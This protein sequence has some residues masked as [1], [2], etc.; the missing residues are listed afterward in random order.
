[1][2]KLAIF[3]FIAVFIGLN[4]SFVSAQAGRGTPAE[5]GKA[6]KRPPQTSPTPKPTPTPEEENT[7]NIE[8]LPVPVTETP[9]DG[10]I[11]K[12]D[13]SVVT[14]PVKV[15]DR[16][17]RFIS[18]LTKEDFKVWEDNVEQEISLFSNEEQPFTV[19]LVLDMSFSAKFKAEEIQ[20]AAISFID[21][22]RPNDKVMVVSFDEEVH[23]LTE[24][25]SDRDRIYRAIKSTKIDFGTSVYEAMDLVINEKF[26]KIGG[27]KAIVL[28]SDG[29]DTS[30]R[31]AHDMNNLSDALE[32]DALIYPIRYD[33]FADVQA[34]KN[35]PVSTGS[36][37]PGQIPSKTK[38]PL[39][40]PM[41]VP[42]AGMM[43]DKG[44]T[45]E[46]YRKAD[47]YLDQL[48]FR[49]GGRI[50]YAST[51]ANLTKAFADIAAEL[52]EFYSI[53]Y[54]P[55]D[56]AQE[57]KK[58]KLKVKVN[59]ENVAVKARD[60]YVVGKDENAKK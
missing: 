8:P 51:T 22:L 3:A 25:T 36:Q 10:D 34:M 16:K 45:P 27:R 19:A 41:P 18:G 21:Q 6:N 58:R 40:F 7:T 2:K 17:N 39:P 32:L 33:T 9:E 55:K 50:F 11:I 20:S 23:L 31:K 38:S 28:F 4:I 48:A 47:E 52:R 30:S 53:S 59:R 49:T 14:I 35:K 56:E 24:P 37:L 42:T 54:Y 13:T 46:E 15:L 12:V 57:G 5:S 44:T 29:V 1:M 43:G 26:R 60:N